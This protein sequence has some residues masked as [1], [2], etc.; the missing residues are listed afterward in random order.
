MG[1]SIP[2]SSTAANS[3]IIIDNGQAITLSHLIAEAQVL[4]DKLPNTTHYI[5]LCNN[6]YLFTL[7]FCA[8]LLKGG[9][10]LLPPNK[11]A[12]TIQEIAT[13]YPS[14]ICLVDQDSD[15]P[16]EQVMRIQK[17]SID[18][19]SHSS[20]IIPTI[21]ANHIAAIAFTSGSTG[22]PKPNVKT[23][24]TLT[25]TAKKLAQRLTP[26]STHTI[27]AT[28][29]SQHMYGLEMTVMMALHGHCVI[30][31]SQPFYP[32]EVVATVATATE[33]RLLVTTPVHLRALLGANIDLPEISK[34]ISATAPLPDALAE[35]AEQNFC[36]RIEEIYGFTEAGS[37][38]TRHTLSGPRWQLLDGMSLS[39]SDDTI[40]ISG[41]H[42]DEAVALQDT[43]K[44]LSPTEFE[45][46]GRSGDMLNVGGK[47]ASLSGLTEKIL[48]IDGV[49]DAI[50]F[51]PPDDHQSVVQRPAAFVVTELDERSIRQAVSKSIDPV[52]IPRPLK[53]IS[54]LPRNETGKLEYSK[55]TALLNLDHA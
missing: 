4:A 46:L 53:K 39:E 28:V 38:A 34:T 37:S 20:D 15:L 9:T 50:V 42:L 48:A 55:L 2:L 29:P 22:A 54:R 51:M 12:S 13:H 43:L 17:P 45:F 19:K 3:T 32:E 36:G 8:V 25:G 40:Y 21:N 41:D 44:V 16:A 30:E 11:Q 24:G 10:T 7:A 35:A 31:S 14:S 26:N 49:N 52:F 47:R 6:R 1:G 18:V 33:P 5:C 23:W 27:I